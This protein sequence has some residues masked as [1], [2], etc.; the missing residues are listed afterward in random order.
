[1]PPRVETGTLPQRLELPGGTRLEAV[2]LPGHSPDMTCLLDADKGILFG[3][4]LY[5]S[6]RLRYLRADE[7]LP[8]LVASLRRA[9]TLDFDVLLC[10]HR[11]V[12][13]NAKD[14]LREKVDHLVSLAERAAELE[15]AG[16]TFA[17]IKRRLAGREDRIGWLSLGHY[18]KANLVRGCL[19]LAKADAR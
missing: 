5:V 12:I 7:D 1:M 13:E 6:R 3:A 18:S 17:R 11:G 16:L 2:L 4:D 8:L 10:S 9:I 15:A 19:A 14:R